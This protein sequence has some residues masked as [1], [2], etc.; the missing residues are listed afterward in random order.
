MG[1]EGSEPDVAEESSQQTAKPQLSRLDLPTRYMEVDP[2]IELCFDDRVVPGHSQLLS[3]WSNVLK[4]AVKTGISS[5]F[6]GG[7]AAKETKLSIPMKGTSSSDWLKVVPFI[8]PGNDEVEVTWDN[9]E[10]LLVLGDKFDMPDLAYRATKFL[11]AH[12]ANLS[13]HDKDPKNIWK[14]ILLLDQHAAGLKNKS[15]V[16]ESCIQRAAVYFKDTCTRQN[17]NG[18]SR[19][20]V[21]MLAAALA[22]SSTSGVPLQ[23][24]EQPSVYAGARMVV[25]AVAA[26]PA[27]ALAALKAAL[28]AFLTQG[29]CPSCK[30]QGRLRHFYN[31][32]TLSTYERYYCNLC[33]QYFE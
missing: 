10:A 31:M 3:L 28:V 11:V 19:E 5:Q 9:L 8:Y 26:A 2:D 22:A 7:S 15:L 21:E 25:A 13:S 24:S 33:A 16:L 1:H 23:Y 32:R 27:A 14:W 12:H 29:E 30:R 20:A 17:T 18:L 4:E 6:Q